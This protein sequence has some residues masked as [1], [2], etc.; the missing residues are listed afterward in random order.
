MNK[1]IFGGVAAALVVVFCA[2]IIW[3]LTSS[4]DE[5]TTLKP[6]PVSTETATTQEEVTTVPVSTPTLQ[7]QTD[8]AELNA[9]K[10]AFVRRVQE[11][12]K[13]YRSFD[14]KDDETRRVALETLILPDVLKH[15][16]QVEEESLPHQA[17]KE[18]QVKRTVQAVVMTEGKLLDESLAEAG[19][20]IFVV[21]EQPG[22][23]NITLTIP[24]YTEWVLVDGEWVVS[25]VDPL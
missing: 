16:V 18:N 19:A 2:A 3:V 21:V 15:I 14:W 6:S 17:M 11:F 25:H 1:A 4:P 13:Q 20:D 10:E 24:S 12:E 22:Y 7:Y 8:D 23:E 5:P 9:S